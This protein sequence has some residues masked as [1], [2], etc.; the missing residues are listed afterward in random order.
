MSR[1]R[2]IGQTS[3]SGTC[4]AFMSSHTL[5]PRMLDRPATCLAFSA[6]R[7]SR[8]TA[9]LEG[10]RTVPFGRGRFLSLGGFSYGS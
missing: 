10:K 4:I 5:P 8:Q 3:R 2:R 6:Y 1:R 9:L 7:E